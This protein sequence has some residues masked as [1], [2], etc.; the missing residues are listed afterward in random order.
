MK[1]SESRIIFH[2]ESDAK[3]FILSLDPITIKPAFDYHDIGSVYGNKLILNNK[4]ELIK[5]FKNTHMESKIK[6]N[7]L[8][9]DISEK[10]FGNEPQIDWDQTQLVMSRYSIVILTSGN[11]TENEFEGTIIKSPYNEDIGYNMNSW[12]K[13]GFFK[14]EPPVIIEFLY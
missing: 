6:V 11:H 5:L 8:K 1:L 13:D 2:K 10:N 14:L 12:I 7:L 4:G 9:G 3:C